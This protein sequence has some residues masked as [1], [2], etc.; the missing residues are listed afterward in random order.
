MIM[1]N[2]HSA[3]QNSIYGFYESIANNLCIINNSKFIFDYEYAFLYDREYF[4]KELI[5]KIKDEIKKLYLF[6]GDDIKM[7]N[8]EKVDLNNFNEC[9]KFSVLVEQLKLYKEQMKK[10]SEEEKENKKKLIKS[11]IDN[12]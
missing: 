9:K 8:C 7:F 10:M 11:I 2:F 1:K 12:L 6:F 4:D 5:P 3:Y